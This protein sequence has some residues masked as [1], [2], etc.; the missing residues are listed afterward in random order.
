MKSLLIDKLF[1]DEPFK[2]TYLRQSLVIF[3]LVPSNDFFVGLNDLIQNLELGYFN[4]KKIENQIDTYY[5]VHHFNIM[6]RLSYRCQM[7]SL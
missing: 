4:C 3:F 5:G 2:E 7:N 6:N 1:F